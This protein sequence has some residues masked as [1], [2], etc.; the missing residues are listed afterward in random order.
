MRAVLEV[1]S[2]VF[3]FCKKLLLMKIKVLDTM[4]SES[5]FRIARNWP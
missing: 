4:R 2:S 5:G 1:F 3:S